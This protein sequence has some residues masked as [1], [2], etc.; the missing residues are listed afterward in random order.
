MRHTLGSM[1]ADC[2]SM[3]YLGFTFFH[4]SAFAIVNSLFFLFS[5]L[6][7]SP[8]QAFFVLFVD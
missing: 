3:G 6:L 1:H 8:V 5:F 2:F 7:T 4:L